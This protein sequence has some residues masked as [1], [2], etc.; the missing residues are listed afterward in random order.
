MGVKKRSSDY[1]QP[2]PEVILVNEEFSRKLQ[3]TFHV[4]SLS[5][6]REYLGE[7]RAVIYHPYSLSVLETDP[8]SA[9][10]LKLI[11]LGIPI[12]KI[13]ELL[14]TSMQDIKKR[15]R[16]LLRLYWRFKTK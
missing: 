4:P 13:N 11:E 16:L 2:Q 3:S 15:T 6:Q 9:L 8:K 14:G 10:M 7:D 1:N 12:P 5:L